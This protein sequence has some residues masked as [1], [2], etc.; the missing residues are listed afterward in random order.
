[1]TLWLQRQPTLKP[2]TVAYQNSQSKNIHS[3]A[4]G[5]GEILVAS[6]ALEISF[7]GSGYVR[8]SHVVQTK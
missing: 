3:V 8:F 7:C 6:L 2:H 5:G 4:N 1:M